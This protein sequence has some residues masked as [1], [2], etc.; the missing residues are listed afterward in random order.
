M[1]KYTSKLC[2]KCDVTLIVGNNLKKS[3]RYE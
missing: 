1:Q 3:N 2:I